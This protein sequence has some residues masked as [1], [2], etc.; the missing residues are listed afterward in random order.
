MDDE[1]EYP[2]VDHLKFWWICQRKIAH[3]TRE[4]AIM[5]HAA[6]CAEVES[7]RR[8]MKPYPC[9][10]AN[11]WHIGKERISG[12]GG[13]KPSMIRKMWRNTQ[14]RVTLEQLIEEYRQVRGDDDERSAV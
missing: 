10:Y 4:F 2:D 11:H 13:A 12:I 3:P 6:F 9:P 14:K 1:I 7:P 8:D 5:A